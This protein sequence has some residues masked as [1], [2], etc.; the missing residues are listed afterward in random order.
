[1]QLHTSE[2]RRSLSKNSVTFRTRA[3]ELIQSDVTKPSI[4]ATAPRTNS[5]ATNFP[6][7]ARQHGDRTCGIQRYSRSLTDLHGT[8]SRQLRRVTRC[9]RAR[10]PRIATAATVL[11]TTCASCEGPSLARSTL[12]AMPNRAAEASSKTYRR[13][14]NLLADELDI[15]PDHTDRPSEDYINAV[16]S[17][18]TSSASELGSTTGL[19]SGAVLSQHATERSGATC[20]S[21]AT[22]FTSPTAESRS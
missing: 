12:I 7:N 4:S 17:S 11:D 20:R 10:R 6:H 18:A 9:S 16:D 3:T 15:E 14:T 5:A 13:A 1:M 2:I 19:A 8:S 22:R 21:M